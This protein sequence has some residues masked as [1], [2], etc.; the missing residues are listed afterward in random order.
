MLK[1]IDELANGAKDDLP[2]ALKLANYRRQMLLQG[3]DPNAGKN[4]VKTRGLNIL[5]AL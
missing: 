3:V 2:L 1:N 4:L 5:K